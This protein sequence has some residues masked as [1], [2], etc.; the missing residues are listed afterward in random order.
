MTNERKL[1]QEG[2]GSTQV[3]HGSIHVRVT[4]KGS[5]M[6]YSPSFFSPPLLS[7]SLLAFLWS[8]WGQTPTSIHMA[9]VHNIT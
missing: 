3:L 9:W 7:A 2:R 6:T 5:L 4:E 8:A 1:S